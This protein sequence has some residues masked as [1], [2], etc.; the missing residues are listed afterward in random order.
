MSDCSQDTQNTIASVAEDLTS[1][2]DV[3]AACGRSFYKLVKATDARKP[4]SVPKKSKGAPKKTP[5]L[6]PVHQANTA[7]EMEVLLMPVISEDFFY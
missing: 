5:G 3:A 1:V 2:M 7:E 6:S 4:T